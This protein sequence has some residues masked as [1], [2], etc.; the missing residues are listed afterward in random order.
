MIAL[1]DEIASRFI[2]FTFGC[3]HC[4]SMFRLI[5]S[6]MRSAFTNMNSPIGKNAILCALKYGIGERDVGCWRFSKA[7][8]VQRFIYGLPREVFA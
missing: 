6:V 2:N 3:L 4:N 1:E 7:F 8:L 5:S